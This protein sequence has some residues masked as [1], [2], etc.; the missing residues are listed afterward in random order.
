MSSQ[1]CVSVDVACSSVAG[2][3]RA[4][5][6]GSTAPIILFPVVAI[7]PRV[8]PFPLALCYISGVVRAHV[9]PTNPPA[10]STI[11][12]THP[13]SPLTQAEIAFGAML[14]L[15][16][17]RMQ[18]LGAWGLVAL[19]FAGT[20]AP[21]SNT[22]PCSLHTIVATTHC[23]V[24]C[25][26]L[27]RVRRQGTQRRGHDTSFGSHSCATARRLLCVGVPADYNLLSRCRG[28]RW[29]QHVAG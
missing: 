26:H 21:Y 24:A 5:S 13:L 17:D 8:L 6:R 4:N 11:T 27:L 1:R 23:S 16:G 18:N 12:Y 20:C 29:H 2:V 3:S 10:L 15:P 9:V 19:L 22:V 28:L 25:Q 7:T 14:M